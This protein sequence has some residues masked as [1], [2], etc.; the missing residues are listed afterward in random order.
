M[1][2]LL[3]F[4]DRVVPLL[5]RA[6]WKAGVLIALIFVIRPMHGSRLA[7]AWR[8]ALWGVVLVRLLVPV[9]PSGP[10]SLFR[11]M[12]CFGPV[13]ANAFGARLSQPSSV[14]PTAA[15]AQPLPP[16]RAPAVLS[17]TPG[18]SLEIAAR[19]PGRKPRGRTAPSNS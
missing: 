19:R 18:R 16:P 1:M 2:P 10:L 17:E 4:L 3:G 11:L 6:T 15:S 5:W 12:G 7:P 14:V 8:F 13:R 9:L